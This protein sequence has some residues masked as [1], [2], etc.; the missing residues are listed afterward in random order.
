MQRDKRLSNTTERKDIVIVGAGGFGREVAW[1]I[2]RINAS[3]PAWNLMGF[4]D[5]DRKIEGKK[6]YGYPV[7]GNIEYLDNKEAWAVCA[8][9]NPTTRQTVVKRI[10][11]MKHIKFATLIDPSVLCANDIT[12]GEGSIICAGTIATVNVLIKKHVII[13]LDCTLGHDD[14]I[15][16]YVTLYPSVN[17][18]GN[19]KIGKGTEIG[20]GTHIIQG[21]SIGS[22]AIVGAGA[23]VIRDLPA[24]CTA[25]GVPTHFVDHK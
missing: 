17:V 7:L 16:D 14:V 20:T 18:S 3:D 10:E 15:D 19:V 23:C 12:V 22:N 9:G 13:N 5:D 21:I 6:L 1:L 25:V 4:V 2:E 11:K 24:R 8:I